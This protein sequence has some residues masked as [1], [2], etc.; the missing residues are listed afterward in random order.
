MHFPPVIFLLLIAG[1]LAPLDAD[2]S[3][4][5]SRQVAPLLAQRC[6]VCH[7]AKKSRS[8]YRMD[9]FAR[10]VQPG[11]SGRLPLVAGKPQESL[12]MELITSAD[13]DERM[14][15]DDDALAAGQIATVRRWIL[16][17]AVFDGP[18]RD[19][20]LWKLG[21]ERRHPDA[22]DRYRVPV[23]VL[24]VALSP[25]GVEL[26]TGGYHEVLIWN[27]TSGELLRR[28]GAVPE[29]VTSLRYS[30]GGER[31]LVGGG[32]PGDHGQVLSIDTRGR[33]PA[34]VI[35]ST[36]DIVNSVALGPDG[37]L[38]A[39]GSADRTVA[40]L[41]VEDGEL[42]W[43][44][45]MHSEAVTGV[46]FR[47]DGTLLA[48]SS[49][50]MTVKTYVVATGALFTTH[51]GHTRNIGKHAGHHRVFDVAFDP[52]GPVAVS[53]GEGPHI[54][55]WDP[56][57]IKREDGTAADLEE[58]FKKEATIRRIDHGYEKGLLAL[59]A[60]GGRVFSASGD[61]VVKEHELDSGKL[62]RVC[63]GHP[64]HVLSLDYD[65]TRKTLVTGCF[66]GSVRVWGGGEEPLLTF[67]AAPGLR[68]D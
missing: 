24:A 57:V 17:G 19:T 26:A 23:P 58:R 59:V 18:S 2:D 63:G 66:D 42:L 27:A 37:K 38:A 8:R 35:H 25:D 34:R 53:A 36:A 5:F 64:D 12:L 33:A 52:D 54:Q 10:L 21:G 39:V 28:I 60:R 9:S 48:S 7:G 56:E 29:R 16:Q 15:R 43:T 44:A 49:K 62:V 46:A 47:R 45:R 3:I 1:A 4:S 13:H 67:V 41:R 68:Q 20:L 6:T 40:V 65:E 61:G 14:P 51:R 32:A 55:I 31:V 50:D 22:P 11:R 30:P